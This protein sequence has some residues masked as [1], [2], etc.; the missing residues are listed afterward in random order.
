MIV[1]VIQDWVTTVIAVA[2]G[3]CGLRAMWLA[4][5]NRRTLARAEEIIRGIEER[6]V[7]RQ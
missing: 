1:I 4:R 6:S 7:V 5:R 2:G 3:A